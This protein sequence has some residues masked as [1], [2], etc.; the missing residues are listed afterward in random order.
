MNYMNIINEV[1][2]FKRKDLFSHYHEGANPFVSVTVKIDVTNIVN[3]CKIHKHFYATLGFIITE[4]A[5]QI[6]AFKYRYKNGKFY[7][8][9][10]LKSNYTQMLKDENIG[11]FGIPITHDFDNYINE[12]VV[13]QNH[14]MENGDCNVENEL[15]EI[16]LS[17]I[18]WF[19]FTSLN[20]PFNKEV[21]IPQFIW[22]KY[23]CVDGKYYVNL[24]IMVHHGFADGSH[25]G[26]FVN[27][28]KENI[29]N[30]RGE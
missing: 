5:N 18:P 11:F 15:N 29:I 17:C 16:W 7:Y 12:F 27:A 9:D 14:F 24:M 22:D 30:F 25:I 19:S 21:T 8:C 3:Y 28:L 26:K 13:K 1:K 23:E 10:E 2:D 6:E 20:T 4:T